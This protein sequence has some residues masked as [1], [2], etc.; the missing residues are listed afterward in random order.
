MF[1]PSP[2]LV[3]RRGRVAPP[4]RP[5]PLVRENRGCPCCPQPN[6]V[7]I[8]TAEE[9]SRSHT[10]PRTNRAASSANRD[11][12]LR[13]GGRLRARRRR[14]RVRTSA[15]IP[16]PARPRAAS[17]AGSPVRA[18]PASRRPRGGGTSRA[19]GQVRRY[20]VAGGTPSSLANAL[21]T[22]A[23][24][25]GGNAPGPLVRRANR[26][27]AA[28][29]RPR[30]HHGRARADKAAPPASAGRRPAPGPPAPSDRPAAAAAG[31]VR[32]ARRAF[33]AI[34]GERP[35]PRAASAAT[36]DGRPAGGRTRARASRP[37]AFRGALTRR[38][39]VVTRPTL[40]PLIAPPTVPSGSSGTSG[41]ARGSAAVRRPESDAVAS[42]LAPA[43]PTATPRPG[44]GRGGT[45][46]APA[47]GTA[48]TRVPPR[49]GPQ[50][51]I[52]GTRRRCRTTSVGVSSTPR[53]ARRCGHCPR[54][55]PRGSA[56]IW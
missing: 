39:A 42:L 4:P 56:A 43:D 8:R 48:T 6:R 41:G 33:G 53:S 10:L 21:R 32:A 28:G 5:L 15:A 46:A 22:R 27:A 26:R 49:A 40:S 17:A 3:R 14:A 1:P 13:N 45:P 54:R 37:G 11:G 18:V 19:A 29:P 51:V 36:G 55:S 38:V 47:A 35:A 2:S 23:S 52:T 16:A 12:S 44:H 9:R 30:A 34:P 31:A 7:P 24:A 25:R 50:C 20:P